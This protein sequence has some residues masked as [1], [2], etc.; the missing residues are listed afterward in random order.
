MGYATRGVAASGDPFSA[1]CGRIVLRR[2]GAL[3]AVG[4]GLVPAA[5][6]AAVAAPAPASCAGVVMFGGAQLMCSQLNSKAAAQFCTFSW[7]LMET[8]GTT[9]VVDGSFL[10]PP[11]TS[12]MQIYQGSGFNTQLS[13]PIVMC[14]GKSS[15]K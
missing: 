15:H 11:D 5:P 12:N 13:E 4:L 8:D 14:R 9:K 3:L 10:L 6:Q 2:L 1:G 7:A